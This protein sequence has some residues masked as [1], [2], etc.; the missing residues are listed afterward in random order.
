MAQE[1]AGRVSAASFAMGLYIASASLTPAVAAPVVFTDDFSRPDGVVGNGWSATADNQGGD[2][3]LGGGKLTTPSVSGLAGIYR[4]VTY[5]GTSTVSAKVTDHNGFGGIQ[6]RFGTTFVFGADGDIS[7][8]YAVTFR[9]G[10]DNY[11]D[12]A[13]SLSFNGTTLATAASTFQFD[14]EIIPI[15]T[16]SPDGSV[17]GSVQGGGNVFNFSFAP[18]GITPT[19]SGFAIVQAFPDPRTS[20]F[21]LPTVDDV[22]FITGLTKAPSQNAATLIGAYD[23]AIRHIGNNP[24]AQELVDEMIRCS[25]TDSNCDYDAAVQKLRD[26]QTSGIQKTDAALKSS[27]GLASETGVNPFNPADVIVTLLTSGRTI[28]EEGLALIQILLGNQVDSDAQSSIESVS[29]NGYALDVDGYTV[30]YYDLDMTVRLTASQLDGLQVGQSF[31]GDFPLGGNQPGFLL[32][33]IAS[34]GS[35]PPPTFGLARNG[36]ATSA[37]AAEQFT[38]VQI[39]LHAFEQFDAAVPSS[40]PEPSAWLTMIL[41]FAGVGLMARRRARTLATAGP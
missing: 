32:G 19:G 39:K 25:D 5:S 9:R 16:L 10:D 11:S 31:F 15:V 12:S 17:T 1:F 2:L 27:E 24:S 36:F 28:V 29:G 34:I 8:G 13:V 41:G 14:S 20:V 40:I 18:Q 26:F 38:T 4:P 23:S 30:R 37:A 21:T 35:P 6:N 33:T 3:L 7:N 22:A